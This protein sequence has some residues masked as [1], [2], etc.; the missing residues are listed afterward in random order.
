M[1]TQLEIVM[2]VCDCVLAHPYGSVCERDR[3]RIR[4]GVVVTDDLAP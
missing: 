4:I 3:R 1:D 2:P